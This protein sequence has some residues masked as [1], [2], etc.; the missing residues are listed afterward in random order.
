MSTPQKYRRI[1]DL[2][3]KAYGPQHWWPGDSP[4]E[5]MVGAVLTQNTSWSN[6]EKAVVHLKGNGALDPQAIIDTHHKRLASWLRPVGYFNV[7]AK[8]LKSFCQ[9]YLEAGQFNRLARL[10]TDELRKALLS[11][12]GVGPETADDILLYAFERPV[13]VIDAYTRRLFSRLGYIGGD[14]GYEALRVSF[15]KKLQKQPDLVQLFNEYHSLIVW[16]AKYFCKTRPVC[17]G[18]CLRKHCTLVS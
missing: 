15:E 3:F 10:D 4:F 13:F 1:F 9:W 18:C 16:H 7:K 8:R 5:I 11:V 12:N 6:V 14:E 17:E 2:M